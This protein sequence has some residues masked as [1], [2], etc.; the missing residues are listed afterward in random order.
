MCLENKSWAAALR[1]FNDGVKV[2]RYHGLTL[3][4]AIR[5][6]SKAKLKTPFFFVKKLKF[7]QN[8]QDR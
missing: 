8:L 4:Y 3:P 1:R 7:S 5:N 6:M 2:Q